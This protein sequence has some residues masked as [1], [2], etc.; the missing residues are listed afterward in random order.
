MLRVQVANKLHEG[1]ATASLSLHVSLQTV[2]KPHCNGRGFAHARPTML[3]IHLVLILL[4]LQ[5]QY[6]A[7]LST[8]SAKNSFQM[9]L[10]ILTPAGILYCLRYPST[11][12]IEKET[13]RH[14]SFSC[15]PSSQLKDAKRNWRAWYIL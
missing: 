15:G 9:W 12:F 14:V 6:N 1:R 3:C 2:N 10:Q 7:Y 11:T 13:E 8:N 5:A 4:I